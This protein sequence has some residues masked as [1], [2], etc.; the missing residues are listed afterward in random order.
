MVDII[1]KDDLAAYPGITAPDASLTWTAAQINALVTESWKCATDP[2]PAWV[3]AIAL[4]AAA[5]FL[6]NPKGLESWTRQVDDASRTERVGSAVSGRSGPYLT[7]E[8]LTLLSCSEAP[9]GV[10]TIWVKTC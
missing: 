9:I 1:S 3:K 2:V 4:G 5:R 7:D 6:F 10:G 8:E